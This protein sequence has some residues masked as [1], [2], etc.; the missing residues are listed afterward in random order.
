MPQGPIVQPVPTML[1][2]CHNSCEWRMPGQPD[3][4]GAV[5]VRIALPQSQ[6]QSEHEPCSDV[7]LQEVQQAHIGD[8]A[9]LHGKRGHLS[10]VRAGADCTMEC[11]A[12]CP[13]SSGACIVVHEHKAR[14][15]PAGGGPHLQG[16]DGKQDEVGSGSALIPPSRAIEAA[17]GAL[18]ASIDAAELPRPP[19]AIVV[20]MNPRPADKLPR[21]PEPTEAV[22]AKPSSRQAGFG[23]NTGGQRQGVACGH[24]G[25][26]ELALD[27]YLTSLPPW[28]GLMRCDSRAPWAAIPDTDDI[29]DEQL[30]RPPEKVAEDDAELN[31]SM[32]VVERFFPG[33]DLPGFRL[34][35]VEDI[36]KRPTPPEVRKA[37]LAI[38][39]CEMRAVSA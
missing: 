33:W 9:E 13:P 21:H 28:T 38:K 18:V 6:P 32:A 24:D 39:R 34:R 5:A 3:C 11:A 16:D 1:G 29:G 17:G 20:L 12:A 23:D 31:C 22:C 27:P 10:E 4:R 2:H 35:F 36:L 8:G 19:E 25:G 30:P 14:D 37:L 7:D 15:Q 26:G